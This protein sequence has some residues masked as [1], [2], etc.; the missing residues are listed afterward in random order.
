MKTIS[1]STTLKAVDIEFYDDIK[2]MPI[3]QLNAFQV[4]LL[5][6]SGIGST[7]QDYDRHEQKIDVFLA[8]GKIEE[9][10][11][12]RENKRYNYFLMLEK[13]NTK[14]ISIACLLHKIGDEV[15]EDFSDDALKKHHAKLLELGITQG[16]VEEVIDT[17]KKKLIEI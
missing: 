15:I 17:I 11:R 12:E 13:I 10:L 16:E 6:D 5:Q 4:N 7:I 9:A 2:L 1:L 3:E 8:S 14:V